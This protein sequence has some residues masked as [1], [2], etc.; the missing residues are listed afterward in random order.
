MPQSELISRQTELSA[1]IVAL[2]RF[3]RRHGF[4]IGPAEEADALRAL[5][6]LAPFDH[7]DAFRLTLRA[8][9]VRSHAQHEKFD[10][11]Y[12]QYWKELEKAV[13]AKHKE[14]PPDEKHPAGRRP[15]NAF[16]SLKSWLHGHRETEETTETATYSATESL[17]H[18]DFASFSEAE[19][20]EVLHLI[21]AIARS[22]A[23]RHSRRLVKSLKPGPLDLR[24]TLRQ[25]LR[26]GGEMVDLAFRAPKR[27]KQDIVLITDVSKSMDLYSQ[28]LLHF[29]Y[30]FQTAYRR[31]ET[32]VF[33][34][35]LHRITRQLQQRDFQLAL[36]E[37][38]KELPGWSGGT[39]IGECLHSFCERYA[40]K[41][42]DR[43]TIVIIMSD[44]WDTGDTDLLAESMSR[45]HR[46]AGKVIWLNPLAGNPGFA[47]EVKGMQAAM[48]YI[49]I[50]APAH[51]VDSL[52]SIISYLRS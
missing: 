41:L 14:G 25:N 37:L 36:D 43:H 15:Q 10:A 50:F 48:P 19:L 35:S 49:D 1:N 33:S 17:I 18:K 45:I 38:A 28:F 29:M 23:L 22:L 12:R 51:N 6:A 27:H 46:R 34:T 13:N 7:P 30:A 52:R 42:L 20:W 26:R 16:Q 4:L 21:H 32:F 39:R 8:V 31:I 2:C 40:T 5:E 44:G 11:L 3:L 9:L 47:P 24:R